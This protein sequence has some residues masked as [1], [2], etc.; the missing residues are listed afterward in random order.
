MSEIETL[1][2]HAELFNANIESCCYIDAGKK[3]LQASG[4][5][6]RILRSFV[7]RSNETLILFYSLMLIK[8]LFMFISKMRVYITIVS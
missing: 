2:A 1:L 8:L 5:L 6:D 4:P 3:C 7:T